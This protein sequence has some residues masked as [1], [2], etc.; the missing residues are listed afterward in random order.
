MLFATIQLQKETN[1]I[2]KTLQP[3]PTLIL[4]SKLGRPTNDIESYCF[5]SPIKTSPLYIVNLDIDVIYLHLHL[6]ILRSW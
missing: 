1:E 6:V 4:N 3:D 5:R 2:Y